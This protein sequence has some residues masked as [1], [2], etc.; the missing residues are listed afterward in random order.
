MLNKLHTKGT[1]K[2]Q[3]QGSKRYKKRCPPMPSRD[4]KNKCNL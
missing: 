4:K 2:Q 3:D 1:I